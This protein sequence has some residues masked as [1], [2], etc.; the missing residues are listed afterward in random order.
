MTAAIRSEYGDGRKGVAVS[1]EQL[2]GG[3]IKLTHAMGTA[4]IEE[5]GVSVQGSYG[6]RYSYNDFKK[7]MT[8][9]ESLAGI[10]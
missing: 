2:R 6:K 9:W 4:M 5:N 10:K 8:H 7:G 1:V 3:T